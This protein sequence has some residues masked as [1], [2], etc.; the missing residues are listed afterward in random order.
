MQSLNRFLCLKYGK[1][2]AN[3][4][5]LSRHTNNC[6]SAP[7]NVP[8]RYPIRD[9]SPILSRSPNVSTFNVGVENE[10]RPKNPKIQILLHEIMNDS[11]TD[12]SLSIIPQAIPKN[13]LS[14]KT[15]LS[16]LPSTAAEAA[17]AA[18]VAD[19]LP[20]P[21]PP[22]DIIAAV[23]QVRPEIIPPI[24]SKQRMKG[25]V[26]GFRDVDDG[27]SIISDDFDSDES[28]DVSDDIK[29]KVKFLP[30]TIEGLCKRLHTLWTEFTRQGKHE[31][32]NEIVF[33]FD[34]LLRQETITRDDYT[35]L[36]NILAESL[37]END[38]RSEEM[39]VDDAAENEES[40][41]V[42]KKELVELLKGVKEEAGEEF[43]D[44]VLK[45]EELIDAFFT[46]E[47]LEG[48]PTLPIISE[49]R[50]AIENS[51]I[52]KLKQHKLK[53]VGRR[54]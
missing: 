2:L 32:R 42:V 50:A 51:P 40:E 31:H 6:R 12:K 11:S 54:Y 29:P 16:K 7:Y 34:E 35:K 15:M 47:F 3:C 8:A 5:K 53:N 43:I 27:D 26:I 46:D 52:T 23:F 48:K 24:K 19:V 22:T 44:T 49:L 36:N 33:V 41:D 28:I 37:G 4:H 39:D 38:D 17:A 13:I 9:R 20:S 14:Q 45:R 10:T 30:A 21:L 18:A 1:E 25:D